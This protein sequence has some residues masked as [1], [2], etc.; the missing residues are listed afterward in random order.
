MSKHFTQLL[1]QGYAGTKKTTT[2]ECNLEF[3]NNSRTIYKGIGE[4]LCEH[5]QK[6]MREYGGSGRTDRPWTFNKQPCCE[7]CGFDPYEHELVQRIDHDL[8]QRRTASSLLI[9]DHIK[10]Q[11][12][13]GDDSPE[14]CQTLC[15]TCNYIKTMLSGDIVPKALYKDKKDYNAV[16]RL[17]KPIAKKV[18]QIG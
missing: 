12:D 5:H 15:I 8:V 6:T 1:Q 14:N 7:M 4:R 17:L 10:T 11:R 9:V 2:G 13:G 16:I 18:L 3:C